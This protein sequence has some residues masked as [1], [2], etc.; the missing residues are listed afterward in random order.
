MQGT[1]KCQHSEGIT[2]VYYTSIHPLSQP[3][4]PKVSPRGHTDSHRSRISVRLVHLAPSAPRPAVTPLPI[5]AAAPARRALVDVAVDPLGRDDVLAR[6]GP[7]A[8]SADS[9]LLST[10]VALAPVVAA[11]ALVEEV[12]GGGDVALLDEGHHGGVGRL[13]RERGGLGV[14]GEED[15]GEGGGETHGECF[16]G[17]HWLL[18]TD[19]EDRVDEP[20]LMNSLNSRVFCL[21]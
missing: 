17:L 5:S 4:P 18:D 11:G 15:D 9:Q 3:R 19:L 21:R 14:E 7:H 8:V 12:G 16:V 10:A 2:P 13:I 6:V 20:Y 1:A